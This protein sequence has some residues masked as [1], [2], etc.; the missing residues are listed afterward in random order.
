MNIPSDY[1]MMT[2]EA[3]QFLD[4]KVGDTVTRI[5]G[6]QPMPLTVTE[7]TEDRIICNPFGWD[8]GWEFDRSTGIEIDEDLG[9]GPPGIGRVVGTYLV[10]EPPGTGT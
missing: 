1:T 9:W 3:D 8:R 6:G 7:V 10:K 2:F 5:L 4:V